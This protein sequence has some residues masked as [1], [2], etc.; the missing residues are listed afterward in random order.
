MRHAVALVTEATYERREP[1][2]VFSARILTS[3]A[4]LSITFSLV[5]RES[6]EAIKPLWGDLRQDALAMVENPDELTVAF[7]RMTLV[8]GGLRRWEGKAI[9]GDYQLYVLE[10]LE[11]FPAQVGRLVGRI[12]LDHIKSR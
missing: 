2:G 5:S 7:E 1:G 8:T 11:S 10:Y 9:A 3:V 6:P 4:G 12:D